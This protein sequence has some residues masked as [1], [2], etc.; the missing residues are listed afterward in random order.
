LLWAQIVPGL[1]NNVAVELIVTHIRR[2]LAERST[3]F[4]SNLQ[5]APAPALSSEIPLP[6]NAVLLDQTTGLQGLL[7]ILRD[8]E[9]QRE[10]FVH[11]CDRLATMYVHFPPSFALLLPNGWRTGSGMLVVG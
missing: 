3:S 9:T 4:R 7:T 5:K 2:Q 11:Y 10:D 8:R 6:P 1:Q